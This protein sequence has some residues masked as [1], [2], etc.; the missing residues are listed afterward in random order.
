MRRAGQ[1]NRGGEREMGQET[2]RLTNLTKLQQKQEDI[3]KHK[4]INQKFQKQQANRSRFQQQAEVEVEVEAHKEFKGI[5]EKDIKRKMK[6]D[7]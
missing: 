1:N 5:T 6:I 2:E 4:Q 3:R 7:R